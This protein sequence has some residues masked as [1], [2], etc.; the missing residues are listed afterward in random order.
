MKPA[1]G[2]R[3]TRAGGVRHSIG[4]HVGRVRPEYES[5]VL[6]EPAY[7]ALQLVNLVEL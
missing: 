2:V 4:E 6:I 3:F 7:D 1:G 5:Q